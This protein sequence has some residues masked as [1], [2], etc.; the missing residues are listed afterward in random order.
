MKKVITVILICAV[1]CLTAGCKLMDTEKMAAMIDKQEEIA[2]LLDYEAEISCWENSKGG[3]AVNIKPMDQTREEFGKYI[4]S[5]VRVAKDVLGH[6]LSTLTVGYS[7]DDGVVVFTLG[8]VNYGVIMDGTTE[9]MYHYATEADIVEDYPSAA[10]YLE[11]L[12]E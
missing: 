5:G 1:L 3:T 12:A 7:T 8:D 10:E 11:S 9:Q 6:D 2:S 4:I